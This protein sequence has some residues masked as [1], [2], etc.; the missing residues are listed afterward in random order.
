MKL[1]NLFCLLSTCSI[2]FYSGVFW[3]YHHY[4]PFE[5][6][7][8]VPGFIIPAILTILLVLIFLRPAV[9]ASPLF[10]F[11]IKNLNE[12]LLFLAGLGIFIP[13]YFSTEYMKFFRPRIIEISSPAGVTVNNSGTF[14]HID[15]FYANKQ[16]AGTF[17]SS[18]IAGK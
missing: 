2:V 6:D 9:N 3:Y 15:A 4:H 5:L 8:S 12:F 13:L 10:S 18:H 17:F 1:I 11:N 7:R 14:Y 16:K